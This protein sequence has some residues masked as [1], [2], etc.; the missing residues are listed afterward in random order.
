MSARIEDVD[1]DIAIKKPFFNKNW[2]F[3]LWE[4]QIDDKFAERWNASY[5]PFEERSA[6]KKTLVLLEMFIF[7][8]C[9]FVAWVWLYGDR[10]LSED[11]ILLYIIR[12]RWEKGL[13]IFA[14]T[15]C[16]MIICVIYVIVQ[17]LERILFG[18]A[19]IADTKTETICHLL[20][21]LVKYG[22]VLAL[23]YYCL[24]Q[25]GVNTRTLLASAGILSLVIGLGA[26]GLVT[27]IIAGLFII[28][29]NEF[30]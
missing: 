6:E 3:H 1:T 26:Q 13:T 11:S 7:L 15:A 17:I 4:V 27:D 25:F 18:I 16:V 12:G 10:V 5:Q 2:L 21:S 24:A 9:L 29:E 19:V 28:F 23:L 14:V 30:G 8:L 20:R 22:S